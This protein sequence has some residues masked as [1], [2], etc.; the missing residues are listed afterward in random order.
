MSESLFYSV[1]ATA[2]GANISDATLHNW[3]KRKLIEGL[4]EPDK[5]VGLLVPAKLAYVISFTATLISVANVSVKDAFHAMRAALDKYEGCEWWQLP[6]TLI[7]FPNTPEG[8][9]VF[10]EEDPMLAAYQGAIHDKWRDWDASFRKEFGVSMPDGDPLHPAIF[11][12][13]P[14]VTIYPHRIARF[15]KRALESAR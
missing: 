14:H 13:E 12:C 15:T 1:P 6:P 8:V 4:V 11:D 7:V 2:R 3:N 10:D 9:Q 5:G